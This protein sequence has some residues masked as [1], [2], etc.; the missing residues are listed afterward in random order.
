MS[1]ERAT[2]A[3]DRARTDLGLPLVV[4]SLIAPPPDVASGAGLDRRRVEV[5]VAGR[6]PLI[7]QPGKVG[8]GLTGN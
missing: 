5:V 4:W 1:T 7:E 6:M 2:H 8:D 3:S